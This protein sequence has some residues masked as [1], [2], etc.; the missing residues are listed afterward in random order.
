MRLFD[1]LFPPRVDERVLRGITDDDFFALLA[2]RL[3][4]ETRPGTVALL[5][6]SDERVRAALHEAKY[7]GSE[8]AFKLLG[9]VL[10]E[11][12]TGHDDL[13]R[14][15]VVLVP[16]PLGQKRMKERGFNQVAE[17]ARRA[18]RTLGREAA[19]T[20]DTSLLMRTRETTSQV[21]LPREK[22]EE[23]MRGAFGAAHPADATHLYIVLDD[24]LTTGATLQATIDAL[25]SAGATDIIS[26]ALAH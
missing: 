12:L 5:P 9:N 6:F 7:H 14:R 16:V 17:V 23:N 19:I 22:R 1:F 13:E 3:V 8:R 4:P 18:L 24:V 26:I 21:S 15:R 20:I 25:A 11:Y 2:P 10:A